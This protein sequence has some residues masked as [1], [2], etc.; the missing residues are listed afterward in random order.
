MK[1]SFGPWIL[2][3]FRLLAA[4]RGLRGT[5]FDI[6]GLTAERKMERKL[7]ADYEALIAE[8]CSAL[9]PANKALAIGLATIPDKIRG[10]GH[11]KERH[12]IAARAE[13]AALLAQ[14]RA[15]GAPQSI[16]AE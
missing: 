8:V 12:V 6:F 9:T 15:G 13:E 4:L 14:F 11:V 2:H 1:T 7:L 3:G 10:F 16:A 5:A